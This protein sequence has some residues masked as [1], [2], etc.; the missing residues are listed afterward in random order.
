IDLQSVLTHE[1]GHFLGLDHSGLQGSP[2]VRP[3]MY[4][5]YFGSE[6]SLETDD[7]AGLAA[8]YPSVA[9]LTGTMEGRV[10]D[11]RGLGVLGAHVVAYRAGTD[12]F[13]VAV[14]SGTAGV[15]KGEGGDGE[16]KMEGL[17]PG[18]YQVA[19]E[20]LNGSVTARNLGGIFDRLNTDFPRE[21]YNNASVQSV[22][23]AIRVSAG[24]RATGIDFVL[25]RTVPGFPAI[26]D[27]VFPNNTPDPVGPY[28]F[29]ARVT[30]NGVVS[31]VDLLYR[32]NSGSVQ[33]LSMRPMSGNLYV[34]DLGGFARGTAVAYRLRARDTDGNE[35]LFPP[36]ELP[37]QRFE[38]LSLSGEP[39]LYTALRYSHML[40]V[41]DTGLKK[42]VA[43]IPTGNTP[44]SVLITPDENYLF[45]SNNGLNEDGTNNAV[46]VVETAT[47]RVAATIR[48][49]SE[50]LDL[51]V[52]PDGRRV[53]VTNSTG[54]SV[55]VLDASGLRESR[56]I[57]V[58]TSR[59]G[60]FGIA[61]SP[62]GKR[63]YVTDIDGSQ[64]VV[65]DEGTGQALTRINV[66]ASPRSLTM[67]PASNRL[68]VAGFDGGI[69]EI[70][71]G[72]DQVVRTF[73]TGTA[74][75]FRVK[76]SPDGKRL[77]AA[78]R[79]H[80]RVLVI[81]VSTGQI[82][83]TLQAGG[84]ETRDLAISSDGHRLYV[85]NQDSD[86]LV[87]FD[88]RT[89]QVVGA[90]ALSDGPR[91]I[92]VR[93]RPVYQVAVLEDAIRADF[94]ADGRVDFSDFVLFVR[95]YGTR[96]EDNTFDA[97]FDLNRNERVDFADF[98]LFAGVF[99][100]VVKQ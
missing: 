57:S 14:L 69:S 78:D 13:A 6:R 3:T 84:V 34:V 42:E 45:V 86:D 22:A 81:D 99:G 49:G 48:A 33:T 77:Y 97:T 4:P 31:A 70:D 91:G 58:T 23:Q 40:S 25:G 21:F 73:S 100:Q 59:E 96:I 12:T 20:P 24:G 90:Y 41:F 75:I 18:E 9:T 52:S 68:Y 28:R 71:T 87:I 64:V 17:P 43:R 80:A 54:G 88:T 62:D 50:P 32:I 37:M 38:V 55:S 36:Q 95:A 46:T 61:V 16:Y 39:L 83:S 74:S 47:H 56:R 98:I 19:I 89:G 10:T 63:L 67:A 2:S 51:A 11:Q 65:L 94:N 60:P 66:V 7:K 15:R 44:L 53:Y 92:A 27:L 85:S 26:E 1:L 93:N 8:L 79:L 82:V 29:Q 72:T 30:D 35:T 5:F 76:L